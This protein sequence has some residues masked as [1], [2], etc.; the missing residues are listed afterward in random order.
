MSCRRAAGILVLASSFACSLLA[1]PYNNDIGDETLATPDSHTKSTYLEGVLEEL[2]DERR[3]GMC[4]VRGVL[5][6]SGAR[7]A[8][9]WDL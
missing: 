6:A 3:D 9:L 7:M 1:P 8:A 4:P 5:L 2:P